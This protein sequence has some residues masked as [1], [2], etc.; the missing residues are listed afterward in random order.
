MSDSQ[1][2]YMPRTIHII[3]TL[4]VIGLVLIDFTHLFPVPPF[5]NMVYL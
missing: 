4:G 2:R 3:R 5:T 1:A